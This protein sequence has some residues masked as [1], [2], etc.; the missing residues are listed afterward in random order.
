MAREGQVGG[1]SLALRLSLIALVPMA[2]LAAT[3]YRQIQ[4]HEVHAEASIEFAETVMLQR[5]ASSVI[6]PANL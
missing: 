1:G 2:A 5:R 3:S 6:R 4:H